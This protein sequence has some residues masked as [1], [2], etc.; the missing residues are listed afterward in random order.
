MLT[1]I[2]LAATVVLVVTVAT[3][4]RAPPQPVFE[5]YVYGAQ[6]LLLPMLKL[7]PKRRVYCRREC[8]PT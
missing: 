7:A 5:P 6:T 1:R 3:E 8:R 4:R 2:A